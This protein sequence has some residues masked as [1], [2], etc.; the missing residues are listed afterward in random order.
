M[1]K[2]YKKPVEIDAE[3]WNGTEESATEVINWALS[4]GDD[5]SIMYHKSQDAYDDGEKG[6]PY[7]PAYL[8]IA[9]LEGTMEARAGDFII[10]GIE[11]EFYPCKPNIFD[12]TYEKV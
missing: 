5:N 3:R 2:Y 4:L 10:R 8:A 7:Y 11:G 9:T 6:C 12:K 1:A